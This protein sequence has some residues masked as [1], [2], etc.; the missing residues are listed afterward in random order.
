[1]PIQV[2]TK[3]TDK[4]IELGGGACP[5]F[6]PNVDVRPLNDANGNPVVDIV[7]D[8]SEP[9]PIQSDE[10]DGVFSHFCI[11]HISWR[12]V[13]GFIAE[14]FRILK[15]GGK[16]IVVTANTEA[17]MRKCLANPDWGDEESRIIFGDL[18][19]AENS[20]K[21]SLNPRYATKLFQ[22]AGFERVVIIPYGEIQTDMLIEAYKP[23]EGTVILPYPKT[24]RNSPVST[25]EIFPCIKKDE[26]SPVSQEYHPEL[27]FDRHYFTT[28]NKVGGYGGEG[29]WDYAAHEISARHILSRLPESVLELGAARG[30]VLKRIQD[31]GIIDAIGIDCSKYA[32]LTRVCNG[33][34]EHDL[35]KTPWPIADNSFD[36]CYSIGLFDHIPEQ[37]LPAIFKEIKRTCRRGLHGIGFNPADQGDQTRCTVRDFQWWNGVFNGPDG[38]GNTVVQSKDQLEQGTFPQEVF[39]GDGKIKLNIGSYRTMFHN[40]WQNL[41]IADLGQWAQMHAYQFQRYDMREALPHATGSVDLIFCHHALEHLTYDDGKRFLF[42]CRRVLKPKDGFMRIVVPDFGFVGKCYVDYPNKSM[43]NLKYISEECEKYPIGVAQLWSIIGSGHQSA[44]D[45]DTLTQFLKAS[46]FVPQ[47]TWFRESYNAQILR[48]TLEM[49]YAG[50]SLFMDAVPRTQ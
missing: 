28:G 32:Y 37:F 33:L 10:W 35:C 30:Y 45:G 18:D 40:G 27:L 46:G 13:S 1:M 12:K 50:T 24:D 17:Q 8:L 48:E 29:Y 9:L 38:P 21:N 36:L 43:D 34:I 6:R 19:Y 42:E 16:A 22:E 39:Q 31:A 26:N 20:H 23:E 41:D 11:E 47:E 5:R 4:I 7:A 49:D 3:P 14:V 2:K 15:P 44:Y 25:P